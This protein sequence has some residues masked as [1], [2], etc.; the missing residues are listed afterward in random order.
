[1]GSGIHFGPEYHWMQ[2]ET[3][4]LSLSQVLSSNGNWQRASGY[5]VNW[6]YHSEPHWITY[7]LKIEAKSASVLYLEIGSAFLDRVEF[8]LVDSDSGK[9][10]AYFPSG[11]SLALDNRFLKHR[12]PLFPVEVPK[13]GEYRVYLKIQTTSPVMFS[14]NLYQQDEF[15]ESEMRRQVIYGFFF[16]VILVLALYNLV[17]WGFIRESAYFYNSMFIFFS[18]VYQAALSGFGNLYFWQGSLLVNDKVLMLSTIIT[19]C[20]AALFSNRFLDLK[21][22]T[23]GLERLLYYI[24]GFFALLLPAAMVFSE[25]Y[26]LPLVSGMELVICL[27]A[28]GALIYLCFKGNYWA[29]YLLAGWSILIIGTCV[30]VLANLG[31]IE[32]NTMVEYIHASGLALGNLL[33]TSALAAQ[34][35]RE[36]SDKQDALQQVIKLAKRV[37]ELTDEKER[38]AHLSNQQLERRVEQETEQLNLM[39]RKLATS[40]QR[41]K[42]ATLTDALTGVGN[43]RY[44]DERFPDVIRQCQQHRTHLGV[45]VIDA[46]HFKKVN[47]DFGHLVGDQCLRK[48]ASIFLRF[49]R[50]D[51]DVLVRYGGE[52]FVMLLPATDVQGVRKVAEAIRRYVEHSSF[53]SNRKKIP[54]TVSIGACVVIPTLSTEGESLVQKAD[55]ALYRAKSNGRNRVEFFQNRFSATNA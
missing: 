5:K 16:G 11:D 49:S 50:R 27:L 23:P 42:H 53:W 21:N 44:L 18:A 46:D 47:D 34:M 48:L 29:R 38:W 8:Y 43:R 1:M 51:L 7:P 26:V 36:R 6:G 19:I 30:F 35:R 12:F 33:V 20:F 54:V 13:P 22:K 9:Q 15:I 17:V 52:E 24:A 45:L 25:R 55:Q 4:D 2:S 32:L 31:L 3:P 41:L 14:V 37:T 39:L 28:L 10:L 40:N